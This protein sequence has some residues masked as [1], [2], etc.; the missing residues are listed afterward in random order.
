ME[1]SEGMLPA[2]ATDGMGGEA[3]PSMPARGPTELLRRICTAALDAFEAQCV[4]LEVRDEPKPMV[5][6]AGCWPHGPKPPGLELSILL[7]NDG[8]GP[9]TELR[10]F[11]VPDAIGQERSLR[12]LDSFARLAAEPMRSYLGPTDILCAGGVDRCPLTGL[13]ARGVALER[14]DGR[15]ALAAR[16]QREVALIIADIADFN[17]INSAFGRETGDAVLREAALRIE[18]IAPTSSL[19]FRLQGDQFGVVLDVEDRATDIE[20]LLSA[21]ATGFIEP[22]CAGSAEV[23]LHLV[24]GTAIYPHRA[25]TAAELVDRAILALRRAQER[26]SGAEV[27]TNELEERLV[28]EVAVEQRLRAALIEHSVTVAYQPKVR[29]D[30]K[31]IYSLEALAR[32][33]DEELGFV[34][35]AEFIPAAEHVGLIDE[36]G[37]QVLETALKDLAELRHHRPELTV[38]VNLAADQL[39]RPDL[40]EEVCALLE[41]TGVPPQNLELEVVETSIIER[42]DEAI[43]I[44]EALRARGV[45]FSIDDFGTGYSSL[46]Y[47]RRLPVDVLK[48]DRGFVSSLTDSGRNA[49]LMESIVSMAHVLAFEV[50]AE[51]VETEQQAEL[52]L[53][54][55]CDAGQGYLWARPMPIHEL[56]ALLLSHRPR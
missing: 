56:E 51:G 52:L 37:H 29:L 44:I 6:S 3:E 54:M 4:A 7:P 20:G 34:S 55:Q 43:G 45:R 42:L 35:P 39:R 40:V 53:G 38:S 25:A 47:L 14:L 30:T 32:W 22:V 31:E 17:A 21:L 16:S 24:L 18:R 12:L 11:G 13:L 19:T 9:Q 15:L 5:A 48:V 41:A 2:G 50:V 23:A 33:H 1:L 28:R 36:L 46:A 26:R 8:T 49:A 10:I 27:F